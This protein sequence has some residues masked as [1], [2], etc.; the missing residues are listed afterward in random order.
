[1]RAISIESDIE[2][3]LAEEAL[4]RVVSTAVLVSL[5]IAWWSAGALGQELKT[6]DGSRGLATLGAQ[7]TVDAQ[8]QSAGGPSSASAPDQFSA[9]PARLN[10]GVATSNQV[11][12]G[13]VKAAQAMAEQPTT[14]ATPSAA[15]SASL[16][17][18]T[19]GGTGAG[20]ASLSTLANTAA[21]EPPTVSSMEGIQ[22]ASEAKDRM[23]GY[24][25][26]VTPR[27]LGR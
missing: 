22:I 26:G 5:G 8:S 1:V 6:A 25:S 14:L 20:N 9:T 23:H 12:L 4:M 7:L 24:A 2:R 13:S 11:A 10:T 17:F 16:S 27:A 19:S 15:G 18:A 3:D 21:V